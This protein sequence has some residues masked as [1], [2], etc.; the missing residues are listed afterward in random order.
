METTAIAAKNIA[1]TNIHPGNL[2]VKIVDF[3]SKF[4]IKNYLPATP[5][6]WFAWRAGLSF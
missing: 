2:F 6:S 1:T 3:C 5:A 4:S